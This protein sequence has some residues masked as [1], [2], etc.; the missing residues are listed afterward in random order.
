MRLLEKILYG[1]YILA[2]IAL[3]VL[4][5]GQLIWG[6]KILGMAIVVQ[7]V[8]APISM[9]HL[10]YKLITNLNKDSW[11]A[12][13]YKISFGLSMAYFLL[14][15]LIA[16]SGVLFTQQSNRLLGVVAIMI[17]PW[18]MLLFFVYIL[19]KELFSQDT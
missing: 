5:I 15:F 13:M 12:R 2:F 11:L 8:W 1:F 6:E 17:I 3:V 7:L 18:T 10:V 9:I 19:H 16:S 4:A 14:L